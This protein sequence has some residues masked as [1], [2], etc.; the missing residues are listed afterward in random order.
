MDGQADTNMNRQREGL[1]DGRTDRQ[2]DGKRYGRTDEWTDKRMNGQKDSNAQI[3]WVI[4]ADQEYIHLMGSQM[5]PSI[6]NIKLK[7]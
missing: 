7:I 2:T 3:D 4:D 5:L 6:L 1:T